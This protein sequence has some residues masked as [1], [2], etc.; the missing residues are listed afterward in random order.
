VF[1]R[2]WNIPVPGSRRGELGVGRVVKSYM[3]DYYKIYIY[4]VYI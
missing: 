1:E 3:D 2:V 4:Y